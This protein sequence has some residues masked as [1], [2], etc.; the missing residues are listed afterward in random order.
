MTEFTSEW[1][2]EQKE[3]IQS[4]RFKTHAETLFLQALDE[5]ELLKFERQTWIDKADDLQKR[6]IT[7]ENNR[8]HIEMLLIKANRYIAELEQHIKNHEYYLNQQEEE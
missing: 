8:E 7:A 2:A 3:R 5:I 4:F 1:I 6:V